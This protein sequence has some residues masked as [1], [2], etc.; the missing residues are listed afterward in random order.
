MFW[1]HNPDQY[2]QD[3]NHSCIYDNGQARIVE[4]HLT[5]SCRLAETC[6]VVTHKFTTLFAVWFLLNIFSILE[7]ILN[8]GVVKTGTEDNKVVN[9]L[10]GVL[11]LFGFVWNL[12]MFLAAMIMVYKESGRACSSKSGLDARPGGLYA[13][14]VLL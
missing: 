13:S 10:K 8:F 12:C 7:S 1:L 9:G 6:T 11:G 14:S 2:R 5:N 3:G 4:T